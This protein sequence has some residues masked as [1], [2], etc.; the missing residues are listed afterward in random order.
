M[1]STAWD[2]LNTSHPISNFE[3]GYRV[4]YQVIRTAAKPQNMNNAT[5]LDLNWTSSSNSDVDEFYIYMYFAEVEQLGKN[6]SRKF[7]VSWNCT[8][9][10]LHCLDPLVLVTCMPRYDQTQE[11][12]WET[13][14]HFYF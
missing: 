11:P 10:A 6:Q 12:G 1:I 8:P 14:P 3:N 13:A 7:N 9:M 2:T 4:P 5:T